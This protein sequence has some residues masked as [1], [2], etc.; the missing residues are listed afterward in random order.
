M[1]DTWIISTV[2]FVFIYIVFL[3]IEWNS[4]TSRGF[5]ISDEGPSSAFLCQL[6]NLAQIIS[7]HS[8]M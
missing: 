6:S 5:D 1:I 8:M 2:P 7:T 4:V 3:S